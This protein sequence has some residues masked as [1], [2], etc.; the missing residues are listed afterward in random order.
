MQRRWLP[1]SLRR[2][3]YGARA[4]QPFAPRRTSGTMTSGGD[5][6][7]HGPTTDLLC[8]AFALAL[9]AFPAAAADGD[10]DPAFGTDGTVTTPFP[11]GACAT[12]V[13]VRPMGGS[14]P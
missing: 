4:S 3:T 7:A 9:G 2:R 1:C 10:L 13:A 5:R 11:I 14:W 8:G 6:S 12:A